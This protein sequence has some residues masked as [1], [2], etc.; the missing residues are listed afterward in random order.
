[1]DSVVSFC[2]MDAGAKESSASLRGLFST[3]IR[4]PDESYGAFTPLQLML[5]AARFET[6]RLFDMTVKSEIEF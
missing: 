1:M 2:D 6:V 4:V 3:F 5:I